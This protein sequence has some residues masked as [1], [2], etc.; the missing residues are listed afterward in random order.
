MKHLK[1]FESYNEFYQEI[2]E[3]EF[4]NRTIRE[5]FEACEVDELRELISKINPK[6]NLIWGLREIYYNFYLKNGALFQTVQSLTT[7][8]GIANFAA[9]QLNFD[10]NNLS[11][12]LIHSSP[13]TSNKRITESAAKKNYEVYHLS[14]SEDEWYFV[15]AEGVKA[16]ALS[17]SL[18][19][20]TECFY[21]CDQFVG[22][23][24][25]INDLG[26]DVGYW[27]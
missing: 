8:A 15:R 23:I 20:V 22:L 16:K 13:N 5:D 17:D 4:N 11:H 1:Q 3:D 2:E 18:R 19:R 25:L 26:P 9:G 21:K 10:K 24:K 14:K 12:I 6:W 27:S 7:A